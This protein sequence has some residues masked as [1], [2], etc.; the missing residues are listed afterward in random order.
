MSCASE[1]VAIAWSKVL[2]RNYTFLILWD[3]RYC[4]ISVAQWSAQQI[5]TAKVPVR[6]PGGQ[7]VHTTFLMILWT[8]CERPIVGEVECKVWSHGVLAVFQSKPK[9]VGVSHRTVCMSDLDLIYPLDDI[10]E[11]TLCQSKN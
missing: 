9:C 10:N 7:S 2:F 5:P 8:S 6:A 1:W 4:R 11:I 3:D